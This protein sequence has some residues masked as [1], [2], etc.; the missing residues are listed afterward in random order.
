MIY[1]I[2]IMWDLL[3]DN[4]QKILTSFVRVCIILMTYIIEND[5]LDKAHFLLLMV[6]C[7]I[8]ENYG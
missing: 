3:D 4:N 6:V 2:L 5:A 8:E 1:T 7:L